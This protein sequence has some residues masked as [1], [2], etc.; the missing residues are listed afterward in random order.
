MPATPDPAIVF[1]T[2]DS[3][4]VSAAAP[5]NVSVA[6]SIVQRSTLRQIACYLDVNAARQNAALQVGLPPA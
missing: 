6:L 5:N 2:V 3:R 1:T 4:G